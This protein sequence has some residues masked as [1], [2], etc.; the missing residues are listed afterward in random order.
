MIARDY[1][2]PDARQIG[3]RMRR[4]SQLPRELEW[5]L[6]VLVSEKAAAAINGGDPG[7]AL[8]RFKRLRRALL[9]PRVKAEI[10]QLMSL[11][12]GHAAQSA[13]PLKR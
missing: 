13:V 5:H 1:P 3:R 11:L 8:V 10:L 6:P 2:V 7:N 12:S 4:E 9:E